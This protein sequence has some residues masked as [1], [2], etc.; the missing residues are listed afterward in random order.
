MNPRRELAY[1]LSK[2]VTTRRSIQKL[3]IVDLPRDTNIVS[4]LQ[5]YD[6]MHFFFFKTEKY[7][8]LLLSGCFQKVYRI[9]LFVTFRKHPQKEFR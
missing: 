6:E 8:R 7:P 4:V 1:N 2:G 5:K 9:E 3:F